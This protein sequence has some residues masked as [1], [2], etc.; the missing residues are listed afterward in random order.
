MN[1]IEIFLNDNSCRNSWIYYNN[2]SMYLRKSIRFFNQTN[3]I[4]LKINCLDLAS[5]EIPLKFQHKG[6]I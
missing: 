3:N 4:N 6:K 1:K 5:I 2:I